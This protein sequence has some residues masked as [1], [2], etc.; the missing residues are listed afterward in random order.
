MLS[1]HRSAVLVAVALPLA[2]VPV[3]GATA[4]T[5]ETMVAHPHFVLVNACGSFSIISDFNSERRVTTFYDQDGTPIRRVVHAKIPGTIT[6]SVTG[7]MLA[8]FGERTII[9]D[10]VT[11]AVSST[12]TNVHVVV[13]GEGTVELGA[14]H[15]GIDDDGNPFADGRLD[16]PAPVALCE[17]L[18]TA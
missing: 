15:F 4:P 8:A 9:T 18:S 16:G 7:K 5:T 1:L 17:A 11:G 12:G 13:P 3:A 10:L 6:N 14:G 2:L